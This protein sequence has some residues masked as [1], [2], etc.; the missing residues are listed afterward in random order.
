[1]RAAT[2]CHHSRPWHMRIPLE[3]PSSSRTIR[4]VLRKAVSLLPPGYSPT[5]T[6][7][8]E[9]LTQFKADG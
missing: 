1:M 8:E 5:R 6:A 9:R 4:S 7:L 3:E 2:H